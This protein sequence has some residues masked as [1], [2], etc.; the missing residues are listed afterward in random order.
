MSEIPDAAV[1]AAIKA[2]G[3]E[4]WDYIDLRMRD[5]LTAALPLVSAPAAPIE[6]MAT[7]KLV[8][9][10]CV[11]LKAASEYVTD[12]DADD[13]LEIAAAIQA[14]HEFLDA[15][16]AAPAAEAEPVAI[17]DTKISDKT[18]AALAEIDK[19]VRHG[20]AN[21]HNLFA[22]AAPSASQEALREAL[23]DCVKQLQK[24]KQGQRSK[25]MMAAIG[26]GRAALAQS[27]PVKAGE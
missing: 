2:G 15:A 12:A 8:N 4:G 26:K 11:R 24:V 23:E 22:G 6:P 7:W 17:L 27:A 14:A 21:A 16:P 3:M 9:E 13:S 18:K 25:A 19:A 5:A 20:A 1:E 10:L